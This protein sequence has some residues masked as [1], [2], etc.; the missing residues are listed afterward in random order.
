V[1]FSLAAGP[2]MSLPSAILAPEARAFGM[3]AFFS[4]YYAVMTV[5]PGLAGGL[6]ER[7]GDP[8][9]VLPLGAAMAAACIALLGLFRRASAASQGQPSA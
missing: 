1:L 4:I 3:G 7:L 9:I 2:I 8:G 6:A 5:A